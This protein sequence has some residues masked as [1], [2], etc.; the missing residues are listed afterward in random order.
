MDNIELDTEAFIRAIE[1][2]P[3][4]WDKTLENYKH[5]NET[6]AAWEEIYTMFIENYKEMSDSLKAEHS[7]RSFLLICVII[8]ICSTLLFCPSNR[9]NHNEEMDKY[10]RQL[11]EMLQENSFDKSTCR[12]QKSAE[13][14]FLRSFKFLNENH[15]Q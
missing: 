2:K 8:I 5:R 11:R 7:K 4:I 1:E 15:G 12:L 9:K 10:T 3:V 13:I 6:K 14:Y